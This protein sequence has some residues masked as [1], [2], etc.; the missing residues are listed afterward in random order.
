M[1]YRPQFG[2]YT[3]FFLT[4]YKI[5]TSEM[6]HCTLII[7]CMAHS[8]PHAAG[9]KGPL[10]NCCCTHDHAGTDPGG[11][12][13]WGQLPPS[14]GLY[15]VMPPPLLLCTH[16]RARTRALSISCAAAPTVFLDRILACIYNIHYQ[17]VPW[18]HDGAYLAQ[19]LLARGCSLISSSRDRGYSCC[20]SL[21][22]ETL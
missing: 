22:Y 19:R 1:V 5:S 14:S 11:G 13:A 17:V 2:F 20:V 10:Q 3:S 6:L 8:L 7:L 4:H 12:G 15:D 9:H 21:T 18:L 16:T